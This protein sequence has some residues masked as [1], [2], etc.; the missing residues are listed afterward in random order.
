LK[1]LLKISRV[2]EPHG[3]EDMALQSVQSCT[4]DLQDGAAMIATPLH[5]DLVLVKHLLILN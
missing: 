1:V 3:F 2:V 5:A 4:G